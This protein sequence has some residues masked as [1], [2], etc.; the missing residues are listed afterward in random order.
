MAV[1][2]IKLN[3]PALITWA[4]E[5][6]GYDPSDIAAHLRKQE[7]VILEW[8]RGLDAPT[9]NQLEKFANKVKRPV[10]ALFLPN[11]PVEPP[12][13]ADFRALPGKQPNEYD[14]ETRIAFRQ[15][16][17]QLAETRELLD[18]LGIPLNFSL[19]S[20]SLAADPEK[21][22]SA[23]RRSSGVSVAEQKHCMSDYEALDLWRD[24]L[25]DLGL[26]SMVFRM[27]IKDARAF[28]LLDNEANLAAV[29]L[30][31]ADSPYPRIFSLLHETCHLCLRLPGVSAEMPR[32]P[33][34]AREREKSVELFCNRFAAAFLLPANEN[35][36]IAGL[37]SLRSDNIDIHAANL[38][39]A[40]RVS[41]YVILGRARD[42]DLIDSQTYW[43]IYSRWI[44][45]PE[46]K[47]PPSGNHVKTMI[48]QVG[49]RFAALVM[50]ALD[51]DM[52]SRYDASK[53]LSLDSRHFARVR[54]EAHRGM[55]RRE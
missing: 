18:S 49:K 53:L 26:V 21:E 28:C 30:N 4:R 47:G 55:L 27:P 44:K 31:S 52:I 2:K 42:L 50:S 17:S 29:G 48:S 9:Y 46:R 33:P 38:A 16:R 13:P 19:P 8:E 25:F 37:R 6:A 1:A 14:P 43:S 54:L 51:A 39:R 32:R 45:E 3:N 40:F 35:E 11:I 34:R 5:T 24:V 20:F 10:A 22:A 15:A 7:K 23:L 41:K 36:V 12:L